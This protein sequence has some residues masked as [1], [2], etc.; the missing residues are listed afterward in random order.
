MDDDRETLWVLPDNLEIGFVSETYIPALRFKA[1]APLYDVIVRLTTREATVKQALIDAAITR[2]VR[3]VVDIGCGSGTLTVAIKRQFPKARV[4][5]VDLDE[6]ML[7][8]AQR[9]TENV[10]LSVELIKADATHLPLDDGLADRVVSSLFF[11]HLYPKQKRQAL[12]ETMRVLAPGG[13]LYV[14]D[15]GRP[16]NLLMRA[17]FFPVRLLDGLPNTADHVRGR[18]PELITQ[19]GADRVESLAEYSTVFGTLTLLRAIKAG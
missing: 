6:Q 14:A 5:G 3:T 7:G 1:L 17:L 19:A 15:W 13:E 10:D 9:K 2:D 11:H 18:L 4:I 8:Y 16:S 12:A